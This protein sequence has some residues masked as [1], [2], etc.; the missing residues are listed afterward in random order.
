M[1]H[2]HE[3]QAVQH[4]VDGRLQEVTEVTTDPN[5]DL[6]ANPT[7][8]TE[9]GQAVA[10]PTPADEEVMSEVLDGISQGTFAACK[11]AKLTVTGAENNN[12]TNNDFP[13][14]L[15]EKLISEQ[16]QEMG[17]GHPLRV[18]GPAVLA[19]GVLEGILVKPSPLR[20]QSGPGARRS[21]DRSLSQTPTL[22]SQALSQDTTGAVSLA[23]TEVLG[24]QQQRCTG[25]SGECE[26]HNVVASRH[27][28][29]V[30]TIPGARSPM[31]DA[32]V[33][34]AAM[35]AMAT[36]QHSEQDRRVLEAVLQ[37][38]AVHQTA[39]ALSRQAA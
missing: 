16:A 38:Q 10:P 4:D 21:P 6:T 13:V 7:V 30:F 36:E 32:A 39:R 3:E 25:D 24:S 15:S 12:N 22:S 28:S 35:V 27:P 1:E 34:R 33:Q 26:E 19:P 29:D 5:T 17:A 18:A 31:H 14:V 11:N 2:A 23:V 9:A 37:E 20:V 8:P